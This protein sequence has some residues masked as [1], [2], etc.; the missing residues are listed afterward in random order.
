MRGPLY[1]NSAVQD[2]ENFVMLLSTG[3]LRFYE[4]DGHPCSVPVRTRCKIS[5]MNSGNDHA[6]ESVGAYWSTS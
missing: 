5:L 2:L 6:G 1:H 3:E 4:V